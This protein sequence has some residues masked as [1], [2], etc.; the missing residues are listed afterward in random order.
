MNANLNKNIL[1]ISYSKLEYDGRLRELIKLAQL[2]GN[3]ACISRSE[4]IDLQKNKIIRQDIFKYKGIGSYIVFVLYC[5]LRAF[6]LSYTDIIIADNRKAV[7]PVW[8]IKKIMRVKI[9]I[10]DARE[11]YILKDVKHLAG[12]LGCIVE[13]LFNKSFDVILAAN[14]ERANI[15]WQYYNLAQ[16][17][18]VF[19]N[20]RRLTY[21]CTFCEEKVKKKY[22]NDFREKWKLVITDGC[23][24]ARGFNNLLK[25]MPQLGKDFCLYILGKSTNADL[26]RTKEFIEREHIDNIKIIGLVDQNELKWILK[27]CD[28]GIV[29][30]G[31][32]DLNNIYCASGKIYEFVFEGI[33]IVTTT[34]PPLMSFCHQYGVGE[35]GDDYLESITKIVLNYNWYQNNALSFDVDISSYVVKITEKVNKEYTSINYD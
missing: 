28:I 20:I 18:L 6:S 30:Y 7:L 22:V 27:H 12:K 16:K 1:L 32:Q 9:S 21:D 3:V 26:E 10:Y 24:T 4:R 33:P 14:E 25:I 2:W 8:I 11:L 23:T 15:M 19:P 17:P 5:I 13:I 35:C 34:N 29:S 31:Q